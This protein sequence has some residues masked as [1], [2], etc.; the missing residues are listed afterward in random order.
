[1]MGEVMAVLEGKIRVRFNI[2]ILFMSRPLNRSRGRGEDLCVFCRSV[3][4]N[5]LIDYTADDSMHRFV[6]VSKALRCTVSTKVSDTVS[7]FST[8]GK[9]FLFLI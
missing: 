1:M 6:Q 8:K 2:T 5:R 7:V 3:N 4:M 9:L